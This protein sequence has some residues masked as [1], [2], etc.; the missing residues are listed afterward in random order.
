MPSMKRMHSEATLARMPAITNQNVNWMS[1]KQWWPTYI[2]LIVGVRL[3]VL[4][5]MP[6]L[7]QEWQWTLTNVIHGAVRRWN[8]VGWCLRGCRQ[9][10]RTA[11][12]NRAASSSLHPVFSI[13]QLTFWALHWNRGSP[14]WNDQGEHIEQTVWEQIDAGVPWTD[15]R[16]FFLIVPIML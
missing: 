5:F 7:T 2:A 9:S 1:E 13:A 15:T 16:K 8:M 4:Y 6:F 10:E 11:A 12:C 3:L 14:V